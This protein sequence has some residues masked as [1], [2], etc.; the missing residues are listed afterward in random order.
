MEHVKDKPQTQRRRSKF[1]KDIIEHQ[2]TAKRLD[3]NSFW[4]WIASQPAMCLIGLN[5]QLL[6]MVLPGEHVCL[7]RPGTQQQSVFSTARP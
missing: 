5:P 6:G 4:P 7:A 2:G 3:Q 1:S